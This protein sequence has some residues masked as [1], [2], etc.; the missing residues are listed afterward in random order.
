MCEQ[1]MQDGRAGCLMWAAGWCV[2]NWRGC[3]GGGRRSK[4]DW[5]ASARMELRAVLVSGN[6]WCAGG[7]SVVGVEGGYRSCY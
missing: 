7:S 4:G 5:R 1:R 2:R 6:T 3:P